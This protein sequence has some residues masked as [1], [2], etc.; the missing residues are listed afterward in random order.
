[1]LD[2]E[3]TERIAAVSGPE[4]ILSPAD[5]R[6]CLDLYAESST[7]IYMGLL[8]RSLPDGY[9]AAKGVKVLGT[10]SDLATDPVRRIGET[11]QFLRDIFAT[12]ASWTRNGTDRRMTPDGPAAESIFG[13]RLLHALVSRKLLDAGWDTE[14]DGPPINGED[15]LG[16]ALSFVVPVF[17]MVDDLG[18]D[19]SDEQREAYTHVWCAIGHL[20]GLPLDAV[21]VD[22]PNGRR[23]F[24][25]AEARDLARLIR[26]RHHNRSLD[27][28]RLGEA[29]VAGVADG[30]PRFFDWVGTGLFQAVGN[31]AVNRLLL[32]TERRGRARSE[33]VATLVS[34]SLRH[35]RTKVFARSFVRVAGRFWLAPFLAEGS[36]R[37]Y[38]RPLTEAEAGRLQPDPMVLNTDYW[39]LGFSS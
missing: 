26:W 35:E 10:I 19:I 29:L 33:V 22:D 15:L 4:G 31:P 16:T 39:P 13:V 6:A 14:T 23:P 17:E 2:R 5:I 9:A 34:A 38:R 8:F 32:V 18:I 20:L 37:P 24:T 27:G 28:V 21:T 7:V 30:F 36:S 25:Y 12:D 11:A 3:F 1:M